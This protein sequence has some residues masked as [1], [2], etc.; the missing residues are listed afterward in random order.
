MQQ[1]CE[2]LWSADAYDFICAYAEKLSAYAL[3]C[4]TANGPPMTLA[5]RFGFG[6]ASWGGSR[7]ANAIDR[8]F[9]NRHSGTFCP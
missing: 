1:S 8:G 3:A 7:Y 2:W 6:S 5:H 9:S 4:L